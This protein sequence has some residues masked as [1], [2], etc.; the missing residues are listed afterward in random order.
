M[1]FLAALQHPREFRDLGRLW[2]FLFGTP[3]D[4]VEMILVSALL[5]AMRKQ[6]KVNQHQKNLA[7]I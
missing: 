3:E 4:C 5:P 1:S 2:S 7:D 6:S